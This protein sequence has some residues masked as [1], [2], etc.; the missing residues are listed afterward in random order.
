MHL[1]SSMALQSDM[2]EASARAESE[3]E[4]GHSAPPAP[5]TPGSSH[6]SININVDDDAATSGGEGAVDSPSTPSRD[7]TQAHPPGRR[8][9]PKQFASPRKGIRVLSRKEST[10]ETMKAKL[11]RALQ[12]YLAATYMQGEVAKRFTAEYV[13]AH[14]PPEDEV[15]HAATH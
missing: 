1:S 11:R 14:P 4:P 3:A 13:E 6:P 8:P 15:W 7:G 12:P 5:G 2:D 10:K 9:P